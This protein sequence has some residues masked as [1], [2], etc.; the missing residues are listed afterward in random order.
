LSTRS[1]KSVKTRRLAPQTVARV[2]TRAQEEI[3]GLTLKELRKDLDITQA[4]L[5]RAAD[6][7]QSETSRLESREDHRVSSLRRYLEAL[8]GEIEITAIIGSRRV[9]LTDV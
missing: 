1:W 7:T 4:D 5:A 9:K 2:A 6:M 8:G 3:L